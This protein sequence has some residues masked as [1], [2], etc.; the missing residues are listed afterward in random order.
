M[1]SVNAL[2]LVIYTC[3][4]LTITPIFPLT[5]LPP[6]LLS[7]PSALS[8]PGQ[9]QPKPTSPPQ[10]RGATPAAPKHAPPTGY[11][12]PPPP[13]SSLKL[14]TTNSGKKG[15]QGVGIHSPES[16]RPA[17]TARI[18]GAEMLDPEDRAWS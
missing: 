3:T 8:R 15:H 1:V 4:L 14:Y 2:I 6:T 11:S 12:A 17:L 5:K 7:L 13:Y 10:Y 16:S 18:L 9:S